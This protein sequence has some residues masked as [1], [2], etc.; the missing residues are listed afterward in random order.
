MAIVSCSTKRATISSGKRGAAVANLT[1]LKCTPL[2]PVDAELATRAGLST[3]LEV[4]QTFI[5]G[6][7]DIVAGDILT[8]ASSDYP[9]RAVWDYS[10]WDGLDTEDAVWDWLILEEVKSS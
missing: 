8:V 1:G 6:G 10:A 3:P 5:Q 9:I 4:W 7:N 2:D